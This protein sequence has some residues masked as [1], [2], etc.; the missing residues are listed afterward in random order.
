MS[1]DLC[2]ALRSRKAGDNASRPPG[3]EAS[4]NLNL[5]SFWFDAARSEMAGK[6][7]VDGSRN[8]RGNSGCI[9]VCTYNI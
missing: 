8:S 3:V 5:N 6:I 1:S 9:T 2:T 7:H 4:K